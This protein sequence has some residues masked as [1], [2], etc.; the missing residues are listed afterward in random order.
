MRGPT[1]Q[2]GRSRYTDE[3]RA[4]LLRRLRDWRTRLIRRVRA[5]RAPLLDE[6][7]E[8]ACLLVAPDG[9]VGWHNAGFGAWAGHADVIGPALPELFRET[10]PSRRCG[11]RRA[12]PPRWSIT[13]SGAGPAER[14]RSGASVPGVSP[15]ASSSLPPI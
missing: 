1:L 8:P 5:R 2:P 13:W 9:R 12:R 14:P 7:P 11:T 15:R 6:L 3:V 4:R 10:P